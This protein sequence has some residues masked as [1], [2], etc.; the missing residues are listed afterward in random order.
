MDSW[1]L[2]KMNKQEGLR[3]IYDRNINILLHYGYKIVPDK[4][5]VE[6]AIHDLFV[7]IWEKRQSVQC[8]QSDEQGYLC[9]SLKRSLVKKQKIK[10]FTFEPEDIF[11]ASDNMEMQM[12]NNEIQ[13][14]QMII[15]N[16]ALSQLTSRQKEALELRYHQGLDYEQISNMLNMNYQS[17]RNLV[18]RALSELRTI[19]KPVY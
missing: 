19:I 2:L 1:Q 7:Y 13:N 12:I 5:K 8:T 10:S 14:H 6:D 9:I 17:C 16:S 4:E 18:F 3:Q 11:P 15:I